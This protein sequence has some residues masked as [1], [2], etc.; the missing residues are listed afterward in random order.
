[1]SN[2]HLYTASENAAGYLLG[3]PGLAALIAGIILVFQAATL[4]LLIKAFAIIGIGF[5]LL[6]CCGACLPE[7]E[8][9][10]A[11]RNK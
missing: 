10:E 5:I 3:V 9:L 7:K 6:A 11:R 2:R 4:F 1:M 8:E